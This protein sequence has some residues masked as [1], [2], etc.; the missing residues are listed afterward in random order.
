MTLIDFH[1]RLGYTAMYY[2][3][4]LAL[5]GIWRYIRKQGIDGGYWGALVIAEIL[6][7]LQASLGAFL[8]I[9]GIGNLAGH[10]IHI[11]YGVVSVLVVPGVFVYTHGDD[12]RRASLIYG[13]FFLFL[14]GIILRA[15]TTAPH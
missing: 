6:Y 11:L 10:G 4:I 14:I 5:W 3:L 12:R 2:T 9:S 1:G 8:W 15:I 13:L 7:I